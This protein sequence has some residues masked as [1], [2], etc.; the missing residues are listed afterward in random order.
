[1]KVL[2]TQGYSDRLLGR[3]V[4]KGEELT[5]SEH[6]AQR[7]EQSGVAEIL[8]EDIGDF[9]ARIAELEAAVAERDTK[10]AELEAA[11]KKK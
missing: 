7:L 10:I 6:R 1:M 11:A 9:T 5:V 3:N 4:K 8:S 2:I